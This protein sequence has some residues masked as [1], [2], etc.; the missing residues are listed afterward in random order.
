MSGVPTALW[1]LIISIRCRTNL[2]AIIVRLGMKWNGRSALCSPRSQFVEEPPSTWIIIWRSFLC[3]CVCVI[4]WSVLLWHKKYAPNIHL[5]GVQLS[6]CSK[7]AQHTNTLEQRN[8]IYS[9]NIYFIHLYCLCVCLFNFRFDMLG[10]F[11]IWIFFF[12][13]F[14]FMFGIKNES[15]FNGVQGSVPIFYYLYGKLNF[16][17]LFGRFPA[18]NLFYCNSWTELLTPPR[19]LSQPKSVPQNIRQLSEFDCNG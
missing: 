11:H 14:K 8:K 9:Q 17:M 6:K 1:F 13:K 2:T 15:L 10:T 7:A 16:M 19:K 3:V 5:S 12:P 4:R 18:G